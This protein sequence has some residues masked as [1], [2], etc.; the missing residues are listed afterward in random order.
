MK[1]SGVET[2]N[3]IHGVHVFDY[4]VCLSIFDLDLFAFDSIV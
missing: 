2:C 1:I 4:Y 3:F